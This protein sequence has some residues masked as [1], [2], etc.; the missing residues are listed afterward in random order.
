MAFTLT[1]AGMGDYALGWSSL[2]N[3]LK[4]P[5]H[6]PLSDATV[7]ADHEK[8]IKINIFLKKFGVLAHIFG[9]IIGG[10]KLPNLKIVT[11]WVLRNAY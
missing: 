9:P 11:N 5:G 10:Q 1:L 6:T 4:T 8:I 7:N 2:Y 3:F